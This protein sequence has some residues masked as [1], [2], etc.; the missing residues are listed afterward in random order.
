MEIL[1][2][3]FSGVKN[4]EEKP[5]DSVKVRPKIPEKPKEPA[6]NNQNKKIPRRSLSKIGTPSIKNALEGKFEDKQV[7]SKEQHKMYSGA[8]ETE[9]FT[10]E[11]F[12]KK[13]DAYVATLG[14]RPNLQ[15]TLSNLPEFNENYEF[16]LEI[17]N[18]IQEDLI[19]LNKTELV[20]FLRKELKNSKIQLTTLITE[21]VKGKIIYTDNEKYEEL[22]KKNPSLAELRKKFNLDFGQ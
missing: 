4:S 13:W 20:S 15:S 21:K 9:E 5:Q 17:E 22:L 6:E 10:P 16:V 19:N 8:D 11:Q 18:T 2:P 3:V 12:K 7:S 1:E 14:D